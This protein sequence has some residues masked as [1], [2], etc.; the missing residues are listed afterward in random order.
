VF[1]AG[2][3]TV[4]L[5]N[6]NNEFPLNA[7]RNNFSNYDTFLSTSGEFIA[8]HWIEFHVEKRE[9]SSISDTNSLF[10][11]SVEQLDAEGI[12]IVRIFKTRK[13]NA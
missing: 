13:S 8:C 9:I 11:F 2:D 12:L 5:G 4:F 1:K 7:S 3:Q 6:I 10:C